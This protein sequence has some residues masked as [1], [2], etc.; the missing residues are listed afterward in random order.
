MLGFLGYRAVRGGWKSADTVWLFLVLW[1][2]SQA[3]IA[4]LGEGFVNLHQHLLGA[5]F[6]FDLL[7]VL[8]LASILAALGA[9]AYRNLFRETDHAATDR[10]QTSAGPRRSRAA[11][12]HPG[13]LGIEPRELLG[14][15]VFRRSYDARKKAAIALIYTSTSRRATRPRARRASRRPPR[16]AGAGHQLPLRR[17]GA[18]RTWRV[19]AGRRSAS[20]PAACSPALILAQM[21]FRPIVLE[22]GKAVR[23]RTKDTWGLWRKSDAQP[24]VQRAVRRRRRRHLLRRQAL[25]PDQGPAASTAARC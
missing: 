19:A 21:G 15:S 23:E 18:A 11:G 22:R 12:R 2:T 1:V 6:A 9:L 5:R 24:G 7:L 10:T 20:G 3:A 16:R 17:P 4:V 25:Q 8:V 13:E 14:Y